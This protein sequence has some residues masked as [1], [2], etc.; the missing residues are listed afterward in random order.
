MRRVRETI[1]ICGKTVSILSVCVCLGLGTQHAKRMRPCMFSSV[2]YLA[3]SHFSSS[4]KQH[5]FRGKK[6]TEH[7]MCFLIFFTTLI[8]NISHSKQNLARY[9]HKFKNVFMWSTR[10]SCRI[11]TKFE[12]YQQIFER[13]KK[14]KLKYQ[15][16]FKFVQWEPSCCRHD[17]AKSRFSKYY[18]H[19][20]KL[21]AFYTT[22]YCNK[23]P[24]YKVGT[25][26]IHRHIGQV[27][28]NFTSG[29]TAPIRFKTQLRWCGNEVHINAS[30][31]P[32]PTPYPSHKRAVSYTPT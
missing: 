27:F 15:I 24:E 26:V 18:V 2:A 11:L 9:C 30:P 22:V 32:T 14:K 17:E 25:H 31:P 28:V 4:H 13:K 12:F 1:V 19:A 20:Q 7:K 10:Y 16:S 23:C 8:C 6:V 21:A 29:S 5:H 3:A